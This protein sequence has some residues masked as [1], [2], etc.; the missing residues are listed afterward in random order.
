MRYNCNNVDYKIGTMPIYGAT[1][2]R[3][4]ITTG[5]VTTL[6]NSAAYNFML[7][8]TGVT[9]AYST[10]YTIRVAALINGV[11]GNYGAACTVTTPPAP[12]RLLA[13]TFAVTAYPNPFD[14]AFGINLVTLSNDYVTISVYD[15]MG[16]LVATYQVTPT[17]VTNLQIGNNFAKGIYNV[18]VSQANEMQV[19]RMIRK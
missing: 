7:S 16:K 10:T 18:I 2:Y 3:F 4:E 5:G 6:Y 1:G 19:I 12:V 13:K 17:E 14:T 15:M 11:Y 9:V 8:Q